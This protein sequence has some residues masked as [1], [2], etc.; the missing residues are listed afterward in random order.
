LERASRRAY[1]VLELKGYARIDYRLAVDGSFYFLEANPNPELAKGEEVADAAAAAGITYPE[2]I[3]K[4]V[5]LG[6][7]H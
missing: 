6:M 3:Q 2:L 7:R 4:I 1:R 5:S